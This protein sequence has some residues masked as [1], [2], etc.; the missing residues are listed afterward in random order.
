VAGVQY[1]LKQ[2]CQKAGVQ[3]TCHQRRHTFAR[4]LVEHGM[5]VD[6]LAKLLGHTD[7][8]TTQRYIDG[9]CPHQRELKHINK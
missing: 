3:L 9:A 2:Y 8:Q 7:L 6:S 4:R 1:R 5:P